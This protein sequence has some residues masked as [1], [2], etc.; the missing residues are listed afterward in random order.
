VRSCT[1]AAAAITVLGSSSALRAQGPSP[2][3][4]IE[5]RCAS[6]CS[7]RQGESIWVDLDFTANTPNNYRVLTNYTD[8][9]IARDEFSVTPTDGTSDPVAPYMR[10]IQVGGG[11]FHFKHQSLS[12]KPVTVRMNLNQ[13]IRFDQ[14]GE[15]HVSVIS[16]RVG[17]GTRSSIRPKSNEIV[18]KIA[19]AD[20]QWQQE[21][22]ARIQ[23]VLGSMPA[24]RSGEAPDAI[25]ELCD[26][27]TEEAALEIARRMGATD[28]L[29][30]I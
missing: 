18:V 17:D 8:R 16:P 22:L 7:Y 4:K 21:Q 14:T 15:Y 5:L 1:L 6:P 2:E 13:W 10:I 23:G 28:L 24:L 19:A 27:G 29:R 26:L 12:E 30:A 11:S 20:P 9:D 3:V 25:R